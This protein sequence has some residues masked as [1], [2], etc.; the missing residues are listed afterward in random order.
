MLA[1]SVTERLDQYQRRHRRAGFPLAVVYKFYDDQGTYLAA[2]ITYYG[3]LSIFPLLLLLAA[4]LD[5]VLQGNSELKQDILNST[6]S[7]FPIISDA[8]G[9]D[10]S[11]RGSG[12]AV[13]VG[14]LIAI[15]GALGVAQA[16]QNAM[17]VAWAVPRHRRPNPVKARLNSLLLIATAGIAVLVTTV[18]SALGGSASAF[19][20][21]LSSGVAI[22]AMVSAVVLNAAVFVLV[23]RISTAKRLTVRS[24]A[25]G[26]LIAAV[27]WQLLQLFGTAYVGRVVK[28]ASTTYGAFAL[29]L[30]LLAWIFLAA[31]GLVLCVEINVVRTKRLYPRSLLTPFTDNV[32]L[33]GADQRAYS[34]AATAQGFKGF[35][36]VDVSF[37][38]DGQNATARRHGNAD[39][40]RRSTVAE[41]SDRSVVPFGSWPT[42]IT[43]A[44]LVESAARLAEVAVGS[45][46][47]VWWAEAR[48]SE[49]GRSVVVR[50][51]PDGVVADAVPAAVNARSRVHEYGGGAW[52][53]VGTAGG[54]ELWFT[55]YADQRLYR[56]SAG[57]DPVAV[58]DEPE[59]PAGDRFADGAAAPAGAGVTCVRERHAADGRVDNEIVQISRAGDVEVL[60]SGP[61]F[62]SDPR[63][64]PDGSS[65][66]WVQWNH[67]NM[68]WDGT[69]LIVRSSD[70]ADQVVAG[71]PDESVIGPSWSTSGTLYFL[72]DRTGWWNLYRWQPGAEMVEQ[73]MTLDAEIGQPPWVFTRPR[74]A[75]LDDGRIAVAATNDGFDR[76][77]V[78]ERDGRRRHVDLPFSTYERLRAL[79][80]GIVCVAGSP[81]AEPQVVRIDLDSDQVE[82]LR[83][84]RDLGLGSEWISVPESVSFP[85][86]DGRSAH[87]LVYPPTNP[88]VVAPDGERPPLLV[89]IHGGP[90][91]MCVPVLNLAVQ[92]WTSRGFTVADVN[93]GGSSG[94]GREYRD[95]LRG[96]WGV[97]DVEDCV[98]CA[99]FL[100]QSGRVDRER[101]AITGGSA[102]GYTTLAV[103]AF[104]PGVFAA[105]ASHYGVADLMLL[106]EHT[107][108]FESRY[109]DGMIGPLP[110]ARSVYDE[111]SP[112]KHADRLTTPLAVFQGLED[113]VVPPEQAELIVAA[114]ERN[115]VPHAAVYFPGE[116]HGFRIAANIRAAL[117]GELSFYAQIF[118]FDLPAAE[119]ITPI[120]IH[121]QAAHQAR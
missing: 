82:V 22:L 113:E 66:C 86:T 92:Y 46:G 9:D 97:V 67:P 80:D 115:G 37:D 26:A 94:Y 6:L 83:P 7:Q 60:V 25:P 3:F 63:W 13:A 61:D 95:R 114:L 4:V 81:T 30:G 48:P 79:G 5:L 43:S 121:G 42:E 52:W 47:A 117:D 104:R 64:S 27:I 17:N 18:L 112:I 107:H 101:M 78:V 88:T 90:T 51:S 15:Y 119:Q 71:G 109:L 19:G 89:T 57:A 77:Y 58:T 36:S 14:G 50:R 49:Q 29:V 98:A 10:Q 20:A 116:Q 99:E 8:L 59:I 106:A 35:Q 41:M 70:G 16:L 69:Q 28:G 73:V 1:M 38:H 2:L 74:Y 110:E 111:R 108:K 55:E 40:G 72:T 102:G 65:L 76:L 34:D 87:A 62:V 103:H 75:V 96:K 68:P 84:A 11:L 23:F 54:D 31:A 53:L 91:S 85:T 105:G 93:Y 44:R 32:D 100:A 120:E 118:G 21:D 33:T 12:I 45:D 24:V 39:P 56:S